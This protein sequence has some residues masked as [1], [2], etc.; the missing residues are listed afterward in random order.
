MIVNQWVP[1]AH[2]GDAIGDSARRVRNLLRAMGHDSD[3]FAITID[4]ALRDEV[5]RFDD[6]AARGGDLTIFHYALP[7]P[8]T[9]AFA[10]LPR[11]GRILQYHNVTPAEYFAPYDPALFRLASLG[12]REL[13][14]LADRVDV[15][16]GDS[17]YN[18]DELARL[19]FRRT[20]VFPIAVDTTRITQPASRPALDQVLDDGLVNFLFVG[21]IAPNKKIE[22]HLRLAEVYK[23]YVDAYYRFIFVGRVD[24]VPRYY[25]TI[26]ALMAEYRFLNDRF[27]FTGPIPDAELAVYYRH[28][29]VY[30]S[31]SEHEGFCVPLVEAMAADVPVL[32]Y[33][34]AAVPDTLGGAGVQFAPK[35]LELAAELLGTLAFDDAVRA[36]VIAGQRRRLADFGD[37]RITREL[38]ALLHTL[39]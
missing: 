20:G 32:A 5:R 30:V 14:T 15:A 23:R 17:D 4:D 2:Q 13:A 9:E 12:R 7:S 31:L 28:A 21:R 35:D 33:G 36:Q 26:R 38:T 29:A 8:M 34:A 18:R 37:A 39:S 16:L 25:S 19:G 1:A 22:D 6:P 11:G 24:V 27:V 3:L 10:A